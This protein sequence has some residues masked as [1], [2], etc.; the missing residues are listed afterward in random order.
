MS[1]N[2]ETL[3]GGSSAEDHDPFEARID[4]FPRSHDED[5]RRARLPIEILASQ[6][7][8]QLRSGD[9]PSVEDYAKTYRRLADEIQ[10][11]FP[12]IEAMEKLKSEEESTALR[13]QM[14][15]EFNI[16]QLGGCRILREV[17]RG[18]MG[19]VFEALELK[20]RRKV[21]IKL[22]PWP[23]DAVPRWRARF[24][25]EARLSARLQHRHI[26]PIYSS[27]EQDGYCYLMMRLINGVSLDHLIECL[28]DNDGVACFDKML[29]K[30]HNQEVVIPSTSSP[31]EAPSRAMKTNSWRQF[32]RIALQ[33]ARALKHAHDA[34][35]LHNDIK[36]GNL[37]IDISGK[38]WVTDF[39][40]A[41]ALEAEPI[42]NDG[43]VTGTLRYMAPERF[44]GKTDPRTDVYSLGATLYE[45]LTLQ[46]MFDAD[47][48]QALM[49]KVLNRRPLR[50][51]D[52]ESAI[53]RE[54]ESIVLKAI[55]RDPQQRYQSA[56][57]M[58][59][60][61]TQYIHNA[62]NQMRQRGAIGRAIDRWRPD[63]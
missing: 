40:L 21:A 55:T 54:L 61:L 2:N 18:G 57:E 19:V 44:S 10:E 50:P 24:Q 31:G 5:G 1:D 9:N 62:S 47:S 52:V 12:A 20:S 39:G 16:K 45:L 30:Q 51:C 34:G 49:E 48:N 13:D 63:N 6:F 38:T 53:P 27:G 29:A 41:H 8:D 35:T 7:V 58:S 17:G 25:D 59:V 26:V 33:T 60:D 36:P 14:R 3:A 23:S 43:R 32:A 42:D 37:L 46:P 28:S 15:G 11:L 56:D 22:L 4:G